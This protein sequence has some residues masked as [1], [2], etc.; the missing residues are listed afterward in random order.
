MCP[1]W[2]CVFQV[3]YVPHETDIKVNTTVYSKKDSIP[4]NA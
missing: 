2:L 1:A 3:S 4:T